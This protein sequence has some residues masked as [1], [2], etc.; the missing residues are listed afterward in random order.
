MKESPYTF[1][2]KFGEP[3]IVIKYKKW[4]GVIVYTRKYK[5]PRPM[6]QFIHWLEKN[7]YEWEAYE[8]K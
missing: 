7:F 1:H 8:E 3:L 4:G 5:Q 2:E 6:I